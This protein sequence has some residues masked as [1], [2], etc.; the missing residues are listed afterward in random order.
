MVLPEREHLSQQVVPLRQTAEQHT[1]ELVGRARRS[2]HGTHP[3][4]API[5]GRRRRVPRFDAII[6]GAGPAGST[7]ALCLARAGARVALVDRRTFPRDKACG[8]LI[9]PRGVG[10]LNQLDLSMSD[11]L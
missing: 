7:A 8:D 1:G 4:L 5:V 10:L 2:V 6:V 11:G 3:A 9:G